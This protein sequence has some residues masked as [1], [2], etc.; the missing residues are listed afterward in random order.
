[1]FLWL[2]SYT[3]LCIAS[4]SLKFT[5]SFKF[6]LKIKKKLGANLFPDTSSN[7]HEK[8][9]LT[10]TQFPLPNTYKAYNQCKRQSINCRSVIRFRSYLT[11]LYL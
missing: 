10:Q 7:K 11:L 5:N 6:F 3:I 8:F 9:S 2:S 1:M 4:T